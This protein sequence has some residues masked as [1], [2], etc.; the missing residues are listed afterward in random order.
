MTWGG[1][2][3]ASFYSWLVDGEPG[4]TYLLTDPAP[5]YQPER[6]VHPEAPGMTT[7]APVKELVGVVR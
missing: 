6:W 7:A 2:L 1:L 3:P 5:V 4:S